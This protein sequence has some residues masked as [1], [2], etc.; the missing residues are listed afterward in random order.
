L[1]LQLSISI[2]ASVVTDVLAVAAIA[3]VAQ[4]CELTGVGAVVVVIVRASPLLHRH[5]VTAVS[6]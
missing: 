5:I 4:Q 2:A 3:A 6:D 1:K